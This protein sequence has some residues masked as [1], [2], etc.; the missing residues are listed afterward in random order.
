MST[1]SKPA[2]GP[3]EPTVLV[4]TGGLVVTDDGRKVVLIDRRTGLVSIANIVLPAV[5]IAALIFGITTLARD[6]LPG[7]LGYGALAVAALAGYGAFR[8]IR[9]FRARRGAPLREGRTVAVLDRRLNLFSYA[10]GAI[11]ALDQVHFERRAQL[12]STAAKLVAVTP[13][14]KKVIKRGYRLDGGIG[15][16]DELLNSIARG[17]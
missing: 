7:W 5:A 3:A 14:G 16:V 15:K 2:S 17:G 10:G 11:T 8:S 9:T 12:T 13:G 4:D 1:A 6:Q